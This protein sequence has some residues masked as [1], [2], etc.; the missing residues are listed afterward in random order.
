MLFTLNSFGQGVGHT[1]SYIIDSRAPEAHTL[2]QYGDTTNIFYLEYKCENMCNE[3]RYYFSA[4]NGLIY[5]VEETYS[6][7]KLNGII[8]YMNQNYVK[9]PNMVWFDYYDNNEI[10][11][12]INEENREFHLFYKTLVK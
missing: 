2:N 4:L 7:D 1:A 9:K 5:S 12:K 6:L 10:T 11:L 3:T 8:I